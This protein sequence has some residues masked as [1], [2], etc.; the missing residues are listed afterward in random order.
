[1]N[2]HERINTPPDT[3]EQQNDAPLAENSTDKE[4][5]NS[6]SAQNILPYLTL[7]KLSEHD[8]ARILSYARDLTEEL[9]LLP[10]KTDIGMSFINISANYI[11]KLVQESNAQE[12]HKTAED[13]AQARKLFAATVMNM[14][15]NDDP[16]LSFHM[17]ST[18]I[19]SSPSII[20]YCGQL[21]DELELLNIANR[22]LGTC[23][24]NELLDQIIYESSYSEKNVF[25]DTLSGSTPVQQL[26]IL[27]LLNNIACRCDPI[28]GWD[29]RTFKKIRQALENLSQKPNT[30]PL[31]KIVTTSFLN[32]LDTLASV[33]APDATWSTIELNSLEY[34]KLKERKEKVRQRQEELQAKFPLL[35]TDEFRSLTIIAPGIAA[36]SNNESIDIISDQEHTASMLN[37]SKD[38]HFGLDKYATTLLIA[39]HNRKTKAIIN[40]KLGIKLEEIPLNAQVQ[41]LKFMTEAD[42]DRFDKLCDTMRNIDESLRL[43]VAENFIAADFGEDFGDALLAIMESANI[44]NAEKEKL[45]DTFASCRESIKGI[46]SLYAKIDNGQFAKQYSRAANERLTDAITVFREIAQTSTAEANLEWAGSPKFNFESA[47]EALM[48]EKE[49]LRI[50]NGTIQDISSDAANAFAEVILPPGVDAKNNRSIYNLYSP[51]FGYVLLYT[52]PEGASVFNDTLEYGKHGSR[53]SRDGR[54]SGVEASISFIVNPINPNILPNPFR[55]N[56]QKPDD[57]PQK[58]NKVSA[59]RID[60]EGRTPDMSPNDPDRTPINDEG[61]CSTDL[62]A[63]GDPPN[64]PSGKIAR[65]LSVGG[66]IRARANNTQS[67]LNH[68]TK[69]FN[70]EKYGTSY[71]FRKIVDY[72]DDV[73]INWCQKYPPSKG[74]NKPS[75]FTEIKRKQGR[76]VRRSNLGQTA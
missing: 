53:Y 67:S 23:G 63:I 54:N 52:R 42:N 30:K 62:G 9:A 2:Y 44:P 57:D 71:G 46:S 64:T 55:T 60:R 11:A 66:A 13:H 32:G 15:Q 70:Q 8:I 10:D 22:A 27:P 28:S 7:D 4:I 68:N 12:G 17:Q 3:S 75:S 25:D 24:Y 40:E 34:F 69:W 35:P 1:M 48:Y 36:T 76:Q 41:L 29:N 6:E 21:R 31:T 18:I 33:Y 14:I 45:L 73:V 5:L 72:L 26:T 19:G 58:L 50:I 56:P 51:N 37:Y 65:L 43:K 74:K 61:V 20:S 59:I 47:M 16:P 49:S 38:N 39:A